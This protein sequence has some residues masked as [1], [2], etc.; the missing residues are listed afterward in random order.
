MKKKKLF[1]NIILTKGVLAPE[2]VSRL[3]EKLPVE[4]GGTEGVILSGR[5]PVWAFAALAHHF[6]PRPFIATFDPRLG[7]GIVVASHVNNLKVGDMV[8]IEDA[9]KIEIKF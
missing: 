2:E 6:H 3:I 1:I 9:D 7:A 8:D 4:A 5:M